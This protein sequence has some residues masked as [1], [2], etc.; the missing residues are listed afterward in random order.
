MSIKLVIAL[1]NLIFSEGVS[2]LLEGRKDMVVAKV[3]RP[4]AAYGVE[5]LDSIGADIILTDF[6]SL[7]N[8]FPSIDHANN[9]YRFILLDTNCG[10]DNIV[11]AFLKKKIS[12]VVMS[13]SAP[14]LLAKAVRGVAEGEV[15][16]DKNT[17]KDLLH[18]INALNSGR[19]SVLSDRE[20]DVVALIGQGFRNKEIAQRL[21]ISEPTVKSHLNR[22]FQKLN[23]R[24]RSELITYSLKNSDINRNFF[25]KLSS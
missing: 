14:E 17:V 23:V 21:K 11:T 8:N 6:T 13:D 5:K 19:V 18:G 16:I 3:L 25:E 12:G 22:I 2:K 15:W 4:D 20:R 24:T 10:R 7:Y 1:S 9:K